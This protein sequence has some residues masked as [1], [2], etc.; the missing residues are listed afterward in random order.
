MNENVYQTVYGVK[1]YPIEYLEK[2]ELTDTDINNL[3]NK[4]SK[5]LLY[6]FIINMFKHA[7]IQKKNYQIIKMI[8]NEDNWMNKYKWN[9]K[10]RKEFEDKITKAYKNI[11]QYGN[12]LSRSYAEWFSIVYGFSTK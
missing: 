7:G 4:N 6:S 2:E 3:L 10:Q 12:E 1:I 9:N 8:C 11:Y 5:S